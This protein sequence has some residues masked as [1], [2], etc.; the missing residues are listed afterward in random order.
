MEPA[1]WFW[2]HAPR[3]MGGDG[4]LS[5]EANE[6]LA[7]LVRRGESPVPVSLI[8]NTLRKRKSFPREERLDAA[9]AE[10]M[11]DRCSTAFFRWVVALTFTHI[12]VALT[13]TLIPQIVICGLNV[14]V[15]LLFR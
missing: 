4:E 5:A 2:D 14:P 9:L 15:K 3:L 10:R 11:N 7:Y 12:L 1:R 8:R 13:F 6:A